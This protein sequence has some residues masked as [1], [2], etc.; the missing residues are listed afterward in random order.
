MTVTCT[1][2][3]CPTFTFYEYISEGHIITQKRCSNCNQLA[4]V[5]SGPT[6]TKKELKLGFGAERC[7][8]CGQKIIVYRSIQ[9]GK[10]VTKKSC[11]DCQKS[12]AIIYGPSLEKSVLGFDKCPCGGSIKRQ[13]RNYCAKKVFD[14]KC[15]KCDLLVET[16]FG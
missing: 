4:Q 5:I 14:R 15:N 8:S 13:R 9:S 2:C 6:P 16:V 1:Y 3:S 11:T 10:L 12:D 7:L